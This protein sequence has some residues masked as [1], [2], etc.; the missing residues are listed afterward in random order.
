MEVFVEAVEHDD[1]GGDEQEVLGERR[2]FFV[3]LVEEAPG[4]HEAHD[5]C[6]A[7]AGCHFDDI[8]S[9]CFGHLVGGDMP[10]F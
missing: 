2:V 10:S 4:D 5:F 8:A 9:P 7:A 6:F 3:E 1:V